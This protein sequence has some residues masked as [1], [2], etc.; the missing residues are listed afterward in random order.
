[1]DAQES[2]VSKQPQK[3]AAESRQEQDGTKR[4]TYRAFPAN[5][6]LEKHDGHLNADI[7]KADSC[8]LDLAKRLR[9]GWWVSRREP[10]TGDAESGAAPIWWSSTTAERTEEWRQLQMLRQG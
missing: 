9:H 6:W 3:S 4:S 1:M 2:L 7:R 8:C 10:G 5:I